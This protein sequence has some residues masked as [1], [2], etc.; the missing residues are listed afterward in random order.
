MKLPKFSTSTLLLVTAV[1]AIACGGIVAWRATMES[2]SYFTLGYWFAAAGTHG[3]F[4]IPLVFIAFAIGRRKLTLLMVIY[5]AVCEAA[6]VG[7]SVV[8]I[9]IFEG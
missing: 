4:W 9:K 6:S 1:V 5:L 7:I 3:P 2:G 8:L